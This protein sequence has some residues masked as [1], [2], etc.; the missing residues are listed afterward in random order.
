M[1]DSMI[2][3]LFA[4]AKEDASYQ[5]VLAVMKNGATK[6]QLKLLPSDHPAL[7][8]AQQWNEISVMQRREDRLMI[9]QGTRIMVPTTTRGKIKVICTCYTWVRSLSTRPGH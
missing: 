5:E 3:E 2:E 4:A 8:M 6:E 7:A 9:Y 1:C